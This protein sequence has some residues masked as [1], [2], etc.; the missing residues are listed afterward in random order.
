MLTV[1]PTSGIAQFQG[2]DGNGNVMISVDG[3]NGTRSGEFEY[4]PFGETLR[5]SGDCGC[6]LTPGS[7]RIVDESY[8]DALYHENIK[9]RFSVKSGSPRDCALVNWKNGGVWTA[10]GKPSRKGLLD[11]GVLH[12]RSTMGLWWV[13][14]SDSRNP[15]WRNVTYSGTSGTATDQPG[16]RFLTNPFPKLYQMKFKMCIYHERELQG[17][18][19]GDAINGGYIINSA[20]Q[21]IDWEASILIDESINISHPNFWHPWSGRN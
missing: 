6:N 7:F 18:I 14:R 8:D 4:G 13:D 1:K 20:I 3:S 11:Y 19:F 9:F 2:Y 15:R 5:A 17:E 12:D 10:D 16:M 21:C